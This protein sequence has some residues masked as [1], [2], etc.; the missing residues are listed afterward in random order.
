MNMNNNIKI[1]NNIG[2]NKKRKS[3][4]PYLFLLTILLF[5]CVFG[6]TYSIYYGDDLPN[7]EVDTGKIV[8]TYSDVDK[9]GSGILLEDATPI[10]DI[11]G[12]VMTGKNQ[13]FDFYVTATT[14][15]SKLKYMILINKDNSSTLSND[16]VRMYLTK[17]MGSYEEELV[18]DTFSNLKIENINDKDYYVL[19]ENTLDSNLVNH[20]ESYRL[21]MWLDEDSINYYN[22]T[23][24]IKVDVYA[25]QIEG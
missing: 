22:K 6:M 20:S 12:K 25:Y 3:L 14:Y 15:S 16:S 2:D 4:W 1:D 9:A 13:Y 10:S 24:S 18:L 5:F 7:Q 19:Y 23:F 17:V 8:F 11:Q 21:R